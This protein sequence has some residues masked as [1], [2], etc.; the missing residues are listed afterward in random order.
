[1][2]ETSVERAFARAERDAEAGDWAAAR[3]GYEQVLALDPAHA[4]AML[5]MSYAESLAGHHRA[6]NAWALRAAGAPLPARP[7][8]MV[9]LVRRLRTFNET[10]SLRSCAERLLALPRVPHSVLVEAATQLLILNDFQTAAR[11]ADAALRMAPDD[12]V[13]CLVHGQLLAHHGRMDAAAE[14][15]ERVLSRNPRIA[16][17]WWMLSRLR[18]QTAGANHVAQLRELLRTPGLRPNDVAAAARALH[19]ELDD[20]GDHEGAWQALETMCRAR[21]GSLQYDRQWSRRLV[22][23]LV[24]WTPGDAPPTGNGDTAARVPIF[25]VGMHRS[26][27]TL[28]EQ[29]LDASPEVRAVGELNDFPAAMRHAADH[30]CKGTLDRTIIQRAATMDFAAVGQR[31]MDGMAW[32][33]GGERFFTDK[34]PANFLD[35]GFICRAL[36]QAK[37]LH[38]VRD[39]LETCFSNLREL[40]SGINEY[41]YDQ[42]ELADYFLQ[43]RRL[44]AHWHAAFPGRILDVPYAG[45]AGD[46]EATMRVVAA[47]CGIGYEPGMSDPRTSKRA[48]STASSVQVRDRAVRRDSPKWT[49]YARHLEPLARALREG[50]AEVA[51][52]STSA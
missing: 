38:L 15:F 1:M 49:P 51:G 7:E 43:Y 9:D 21:R 36:P 40:F 41:S 3:A 48:V 47:H 27:T 28:P 32:R 14:A 5:Q 8:A 11:C 4:D 12:P 35:V 34:Q 17:G 39:P 18:K 23:D 24:A 20:I 37:I 52:A 33:L 26:G 2:A 6:A 29:L 19:K 22:D 46:T 10:A 30:Y 25:I 50:G 13:A 31:Y 44:M 42:L 16:N 45:L